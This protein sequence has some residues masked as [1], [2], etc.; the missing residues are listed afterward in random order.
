MASHGL[1]LVSP[2]VL[3]ACWS[4][5]SASH[6]DRYLEHCHV[7]PWECFLH[8]CEPTVRR[9]W[10]VR[11]M[12]VPLAVL[13]AR[14]FP[15]VRRAEVGPLIVCSA[16]GVL[17]APCSSDC[18]SDISSDVSSA[19]SPFLHASLSCSL[20]RVVCGAFV[21]CPCARPGQFICMYFSVAHP[22]FALSL[23][24]SFFTAMC[25]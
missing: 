17:S 12:P 15:L 19:R 21:H 10:A 8:P 22:S 9:A 7:V 14:W 11:C 4:F 25:S 20:P 6:S 1:A 3:S 5:C 18:P 16:A 2:V 13:S 24:Q 23:S